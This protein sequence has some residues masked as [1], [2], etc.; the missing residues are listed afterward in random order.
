MLLTLREQLYPMAAPRYPGVRRHAG[1]GEV[2]RALEL[3]LAQQLV[4]QL[5][6]ARDAAWFD[7]V[8]SVLADQPDAP[9][10]A[11]EGNSR[12]AALRELAKIPAA[13][14]EAYGATRFPARALAPER[15]RRA[16]ARRAATCR[17]RLR[18]R[19]PC[20]SQQHR[21]FCA[22]KPDQRNAP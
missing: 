16:S 11:R 5:S 10:V 7:W 4:Q 17:V 18:A 1:A 15:P 13:I 12:C 2:L 19:P 8:D 20:S 14:D 21:F 6:P 3:D 9:P 22:S